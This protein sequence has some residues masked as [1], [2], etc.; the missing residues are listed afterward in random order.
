LNLN[1]LCCF[2]FFKKPDKQKSAI[3]KISA[4]WGV[5]RDPCYK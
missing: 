3:L 4:Y 1:I 5:W 2:N